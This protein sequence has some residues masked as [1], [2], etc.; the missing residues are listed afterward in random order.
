MCNSFR[1]LVK[2]RLG[3]E[4]LVDF[5]KGRIDFG[6]K[7]DKIF[8][9]LRELVN[10]L[11][12]VVVGVGLEKI[13]KDLDLIHP[14]FPLIFLAIVY[15]AIILSWWGWNFGTICGPAENNSWLFLIDYILLILYWFLI[16]KSE[17]LNWL[18]LLFLIMFFLY[19][20]WE[21][22]RWWLFKSEEA[23]RR[24]KKAENIN[25][26]FFVIISLLFAINFAY[27]IGEEKTW[28][29]IN[30][31]I[32]FPLLL[33]YRFKIFEAY[34]LNEEEVE[35][36]M[37]IEILLVKK[38]KEIVLSARAHLSNYKV[39]AAILSETNKI[40]VGCNIEFDNYSN[41]I[42]AEE[43]AI[44]ALVAGGDKKPI[45][46]A[47]FTF[48]DNPIY[49]CGMCRQSL[50]EIGGKDLKVIAAYKDKYEIKTMG[51]LL[52]EAFELKKR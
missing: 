43:A 49:P 27:G 37:N 14:T 29:M 26:I 20:V 18:L 25:R 22:I 35:N 51:E 2:E 21:C 36:K 50:F 39:G 5:L 1:R 17:N 12:A 23:G 52:P 16:N 7:T 46:I 13:G 8:D 38:A 4:D 34:K 42:H 6:N 19:Y 48:D 28:K 11:F 47:I 32:F 33:Y 3:M 10:M 9:A 15:L 45:A 41:T 24:I 40:Y 44:S 31:A 30:V